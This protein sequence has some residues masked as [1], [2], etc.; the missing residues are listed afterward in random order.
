MTFIYILLSILITLMLIYLY[1]IMPNNIKKQDMNKFYDFLY[2]HRGFHD[3]K[4]DAP[5]NSMLS[6][7]KAVENGYGMELDIQ[8]T[9]D[10]KVVVFH[11]FTLDRV[12]GVK[13]NVI[14]FTYDEI[15]N[16]KLLQSNQTIPLL[17]DVLNEV[18]GKTPLIVEFK[19]Q[20]PKKVPVLCQEANKI[21][22][23]YNGLYC[24]ES[25]NP[26]AVV[27]YKE[28]C[29]DVVRGQLSC[30]YGDYG[31]GKPQF[32]ALEYL[33]MNF[34][35]KPDFIAYDK[36]GYNNI[37]RRLCRNL[38]KNTAVV[39]TLYNQEDYDKAKPH[40]DLFIFEGFKPK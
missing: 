31:K 9:K 21:L 14:D 35:A 15:K 32:K 22:Q 34:K 24:M 4:S 6:F 12:C 11:D 26:K 19:V 38:F 5:E 3:N 10:N 17:Q 33:L 18:A 2:A 36:A 27:W 16:H 8:I 39:W 29:P 1:L 28:N 13:G 37:S 7:T 25:F 20:D 40:F 23:N 30:N